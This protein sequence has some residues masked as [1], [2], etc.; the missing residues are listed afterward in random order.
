MHG[1]DFDILYLNIT[2]IY[3]LELTKRVTQKVIGKA[4][5]VLLCYSAQVG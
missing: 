1:L 5:Q 2:Y 4:F 3:P